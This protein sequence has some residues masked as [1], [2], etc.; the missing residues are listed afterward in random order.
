MAE[1]YLVKG[2]FDFL[3]KAKPF[4]DK[5]KDLFFLALSYETLP[6]LSIFKKLKFLIF[7]FD[8]KKFSLME[9]LKILKDY[10][11][12]DE[13]LL[14]FFSK[15][16]KKRLRKVFNKLEDCKIDYLISLMEEKEE[17]IKNL[18]E[19]IKEEIIIQKR[20]EE[21]LKKVGELKPLR[22]EKKEELWQ[23]IK[24]RIK[25][26]EEIKSPADFI[27]LLLAIFNKVF[28]ITRLMKFLFLLKK[29]LNID[30]YF[31]NY[32]RFLPYSL[33]P[34][35]KKVYNDL[36]DLVKKGLV[37]RVLHPKLKISEIEK[38]IISYFDEEVISEYKLTEKGLK[39]AQRIINIIN[40]I[41][42]NL[43]KGITKIKSQ[44]QKY[45]L[46]QLLKEIYTKYPEYQKKSKIWEKIKDV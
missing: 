34:F 31:K 4:L 27:I 42:K 46:L 25:E 14:I 44:Y 33:G 43:I 11:K 18:P 32:Y 36:E 23:R 29:E 19:I 8:G 9:N 3:K 6:L 37:K 40:K 12:K 24:E 41:D 16:E 10:F 28:G 38:E 45:S 26:K 7:F 2:D 1:A 15:K 20:T 35:D 13:Y 5:K 39:E 30:K 22:E 21:L 17:K